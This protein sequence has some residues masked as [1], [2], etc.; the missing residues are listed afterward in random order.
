LLEAGDFID[1]DND[2]AKQL[3]DLALSALDREAVREALE[4]I[5]R[6]GIKL[7][8][9]EE[10]DGQNYFVD[11]NGKV[12]SKETLANILLHAL[13]RE[14]NAAPREEAAGCAGTIEHSP[15]A[16]APDVAR[17]LERMHEVYGDSIYHE[18]AALLSL[19]QVEIKGHMRIED[20]LKARIAE[21]EKELET[22]RGKHGST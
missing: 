12:V 6:R 4:I 19:A 13:K 9:R 10:W 7:P 3:C 16:A 17:R 18:A 1:P 22:L 20:E 5:A 14:P 2:Q 15:A 8:I 11:A 21:L